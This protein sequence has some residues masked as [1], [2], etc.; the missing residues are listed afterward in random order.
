[1]KIYDSLKY[2]DDFTVCLGAINK[3]IEEIV[4]H[5]NTKI[6]NTGAFLECIY[7]KKV[8]LNEGLDT[9]GAYVFS[10]CDVL[11]KITF[12]STL[13]K[14][15][16][17]AFHDCINLKEIDLSNTSLEVIYSD[18]F[19][20]FENIKWPSSIHI[21]ENLIYN[22][23]YSIC[24]G[25]K[26]DSI[27]SIVLHPN[28]KIINDSAFA[29]CF[30]LKKVIFNEGL[31]EIGPYV[32]KNCPSLEKINF[33]SAL[34]IIAKDAFG[35]CEN[36][37]QIDLS[38]TKIKGLGDYLFAYCKNLESIKLPNT[39]EYLNR[40]CLYDTSVK[41]LILPKSVTFIHADF[42]NQKITLYTNKEFTN[43][44]KNVTI[45]P[46]TLEELIDQGKSFKEA[47]NIINENEER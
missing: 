21:Y 3:E 25:P 28:T 32:F 27:E 6:I 33:P 11:E 17:E 8:S 40:Y 43:L 41:K 13:K 9:I 23:D 2:N 15:Y 14:I 36:L 45:K 37:K 35:E 46:F 31:E 29:N 20:N 42:T 26:F 19:D 5:P 4:L 47:N 38:N 18:S 39:L 10:N 24:F 1:M 44:N 7:L 12:P 30:D 22:K 16:G 34:E